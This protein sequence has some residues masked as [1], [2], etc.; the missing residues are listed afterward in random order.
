MTKKRKNTIENYNSI[1]NSST[2]SSKKAFKRF[3]WADSLH[4]DFMLAVWDIGL[5]QLRADQV[6][7]FKTNSRGKSEVEIGLDPADDVNCVEQ[8]MN[9]LSRYRET[10]R[11][12]PGFYEQD[13]YQQAKS[14]SV[15]T[16][17]IGETETCVDISL[18][19]ETRR[20]GAE[21]VKE[22]LSRDNVVGDTVQV[23]P[24]STLMRRTIDKVSNDMI[25]LRNLVGSL[26]QTLFSLEKNHAYMVGKYEYA[27]KR[28]KQEQLDFARGSHGESASTS[29]S[30]ERQQMVSV[31]TLPFD[32]SMRQ[33]DL[34][35]QQAVVSNHNHDHMR[36]LQ[37]NMYALEKTQKQLH[38]RA[39]REYQQFAPQGSLSY[40]M[41]QT[42]VSSTLAPR[43]GNDNEEQDDDD[44][45]NGARL[46]ILPTTPTRE[47]TLHFNQKETGSNANGSLDFGAELMWNGSDED[48][49]ASDEDIDLFDFL[50]GTPSP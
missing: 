38:A 28:E 14:F 24:N 48:I 6:A 7:D 27:K 34:P 30:S 29:T 4:Y 13:E 45:E 36:S 32:E 19:Q 15:K 12:L 16:G 33:Y 41:P 20:T 2:N 25:E 47:P 17:E 46:N 39:Q 3:L 37:F 35:S 1:E 49:H 50:E 22:D 18:T 9:A 23:R 43:F 8:M 10:T 11:D 40:H 44:D 31:G 42:S 5:N 26:N 21:P